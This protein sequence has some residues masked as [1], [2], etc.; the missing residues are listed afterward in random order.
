MTNILKKLTMLAAATLLGA[1]A[2]AVLPSGQSQSISPWKTFGEA[3]NAYDSITP[4]HTM[5]ADLHKLGYDP[6]TV[7][8]L[9][10]F[11]YVDIMNKFGSVMDKN[12]LP[13]GM[14]SCL[15]ARDNCTG[16]VARVQNLNHQRIGSVPKDLLGFGQKTMTTGWAFESTIV[17]VGDTVVYKLW[18]GTPDIETYEKKSTPLG[19]L[20][21]LGGAIPKP[22]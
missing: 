5:R 19:P 9:S 14:Q 2:S 11:N 4:H 12:D 10:I 22:F 6:G 1:C 15:K 17:M 7:P 20:Q 8:N 21:Q 18:S 3:K 16:Y 13:D